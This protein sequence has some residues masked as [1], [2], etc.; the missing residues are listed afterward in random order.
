MSLTTRR[1]LNRY[2]WTLLTMPQDVIDRVHSL[3]RRSYANRRLTF[4]WRS[5]E[6]MSNALDDID[7]DSHDEHAYYNSDDDDDDENTY[8]DDL[9]LSCTFD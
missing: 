6:E 8:N 2:N 3:A 7:N 1:R 4:A 5:G 9:S